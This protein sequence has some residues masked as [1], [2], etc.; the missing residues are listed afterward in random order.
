MITMDTDARLLLAREQQEQLRRAFEPHAR[1]PIAA[2]PAP[3]QQRVTLLGR[4]R[5]RAQ[6]AALL[7]RVL[8]GTARQARRS[9][10]VSRALKQP[11]GDGG[12]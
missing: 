9:R 6:V 10:L 4:R 8:R 11:Q 5:R 2:E 7:A 1:A 12:P 3:K